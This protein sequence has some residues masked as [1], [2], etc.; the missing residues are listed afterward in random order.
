MT[1]QFRKRNTERSRQLRREAS[2]AERLLWTYLN[3]GKIDGH[4]F[5]KQFEIGPYY[6][7]LTCR[8]QKLVVEID[9]W[10]HDVRQSHDKHRDEY[11][12]AVG[13]RILRF[14]NEAVM[15]NIEG[16]VQTIAV[17]LAEGPS[18]SP[19]RKREGSN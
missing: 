9:G 12:R 14:S 2:P 6:A 1:G 7:D 5:T 10:S 13:Y 16:V 4:R 18:P 17:A 8:S 3:A 11:M 19:S 15:S